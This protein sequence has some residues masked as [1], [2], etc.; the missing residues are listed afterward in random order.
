M[1]ESRDEGRQGRGIPGP[2]LRFPLSVVLPGVVVAASAALSV[3]A[4]ALPWLERLALAA[5]GLLLW[6]LLEYLLHRVLLH[7]IEPFRRWHQDHHDWPR[8]PIRVPLLFSL[9]LL[10]LLT[11]A[12]LLLLGSAAGAAPLVCGL[13]L[14]H[15]LQESVHDRLHRGPAPPASWLERRRLAHRVHHVDDETVE[16]GTLTGLWDRLLGT[17]RRS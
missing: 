10:V 17:L 14:G 8:Q 5:A 15:V 2:A 6:T 9:P 7:R 4:S 16:F 1:A 13:V 11:G 12:P 3:R